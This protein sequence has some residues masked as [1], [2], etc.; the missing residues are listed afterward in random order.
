M[1]GTITFCFLCGGT[2]IVCDLV[3]I[4][5]LTLQPE[6]VEYIQHIYILTHCKPEGVDK[7][8]GWKDTWNR[9]GANENEEIEYGFTAN[10]EDYWENSY[11]GEE[12][13]RNIGLVNGA[14]IHS[15][16]YDLLHRFLETRA[17]ESSNMQSLRMSDHDLFEILKFVQAES[18]NGLTYFMDDSIIMTMGKEFEY[19]SGCDWLVRNPIAN[20]SD[21]PTLQLTLF[22]PPSVENQLLFLPTVALHAIFDKLELNHL[23]SLQ[24]VSQT[25]KLYVKSSRE[26]Q[27]RCHIHLFV[28]LL[29]EY[30]T[31]I[32]CRLIDWNR[33]IAGSENLRNLR[34]IGLII[35]RLHHYMPQIIEILGSNT[36]CELN[37]EPR[38]EFIYTLVNE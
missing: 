31:Q 37:Q 14:L 4:E 2:S 7:S 34:R 23:A 27:I 19:F 21:L 16:C 26:W 5:A 12:F 22:P 8:P 29:P 30:H 36:Y 17:Q 1:D 32:K 38:N 24:R 3:R 20:L 10:E 25:L 18:L 6:D 13:Y 9:S 15:I 33:A 35:Q 11:R 28:D